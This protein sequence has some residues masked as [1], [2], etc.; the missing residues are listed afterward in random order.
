MTKIS[1]NLQNKKFPPLRDDASAY[2]TDVEFFLHKPG[3]IRFRLTTASTAEMIAAGMILRK[4]W[5]GA[6]LVRF[7]TVGR[8]GEAGALRFAVVFFQFPANETEALSGAPNDLLEAAWTRAVSD[9]RA[10]VMRAEHAHCIAAVDG[11]SLP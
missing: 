1:L 6:R 2:L 9:S 11:A 4:S 10:D 8:S 3:G 7:R 5:R